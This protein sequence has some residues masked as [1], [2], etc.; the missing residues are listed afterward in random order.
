MFQAGEDLPSSAL[1]LQLDTGP[2]VASPPRA[3]DGCCL[4][5]LVLPELLGLVSELNVGGGCDTSLNPLFLF[6][7]VVY[8]GDRGP[9]LEPVP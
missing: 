3:R 8:A 5:G 2:P 4:L 6:V 1:L 9:A 7:V